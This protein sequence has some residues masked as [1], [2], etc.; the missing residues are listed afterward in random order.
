[1]KYHSLIFTHTR[2][3][4]GKYLV[5]GVVRADVMPGWVVLAN[6]NSENTEN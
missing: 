2:N 4:T 6:R 5:Y 1:M 3:G